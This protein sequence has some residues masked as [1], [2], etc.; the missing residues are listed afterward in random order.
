MSAMFSIAF[1][2]SDA[3]NFPNILLVMTHSSYADLTG[4]VLVS[5]Q[6]GLTS[7]SKTAFEAA[8][9][10]YIPA[11]I[12][13]SFDTGRYNASDLY[14]VLEENQ[15]AE[16]PLHYCFGP[17]LFQAI[18]QESQTFKVILPSTHPRM[19]V[20]VIARTYDSTFFDIRTFLHLPENAFPE[21][22]IEWYVL[23]F[24]GVT[25]LT[26]AFARRGKKRI[27]A[28]LNVSARQRTPQG[29]GAV[30]RKTL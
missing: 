7:F 8:T 18:S 3:A 27:K 9:D 19:L 21:Y 2:S 4:D 5:W 16:Q 30:W 13:T 17:F 14:A 25:L 12:I 22:P 10:G 1:N 6:G 26:L 15:T 29:C 23:L 28:R 20:L 24:M 11:Q